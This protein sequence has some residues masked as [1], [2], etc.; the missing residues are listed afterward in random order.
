MDAKKPRQPETAPE[1]KKLSSKPHHG[2]KWPPDDL[3]QV[4]TTINATP[5]IFER[6][7]PASARAAMNPEL[8]V[9]AVDI[10]SGPSGGAPKQFCA[11]TIE[12]VQAIYEATPTSSRCMY[13]VI[14]GPPRPC[15]A[16]FDLETK[17][18]NAVRWQPEVAADE[19]I[20]AATRQ[21]HLQAAAQLYMD[22]SLKVEVITLRCDR[23]NKFSRHVLLKTTVQ[24]KDCSK[25]MP[26]R[27]P[28]DAKTLARLVSTVVS[29]EAASLIDH[30]VYHP[31]RC[32]RLHRS[33][34]LG[35]PEKA[36]FV[37]EP[38]ACTLIEPS[39]GITAVLVPVSET[40]VQPM[41]QAERTM[42]T[43][44]EVDHLMR[45]NDAQCAST[46]ASMTRPRTHC[47]TAVAEK[48]FNWQALLALSGAQ[49]PAMELLPGVHPHI[50]AQ[51]EAPGLPPTPLDGMRQWGEAQ[52]R[53]L[54]C[55]DV[56]AGSP[57]MGW[58]YVR[59]L[60]PE[61]V[62]LELHAKGGTCLTIGRR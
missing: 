38:T 47:N 24:N 51:C 2:G 46:I 53:W 13:E 56:D 59:A 41:V 54:G 17:V 30:G 23:A 37:L 49:R 32:F 45:R 26:L 39:F 34:K 42:R 11:A 1:A 62:Y 10:P 40:L 29:A 43:F 21:L 31:N 18:T 27:S 33:F 5:L 48:A 14:Q 22:E 8:R 52:L 6:L 19:V 20:A 55:K 12:H 9:W 36:P 3:N 58:S 4:A 7:A 61:E 57:V 60:D 44:S 50:A 28:A 16:Y 35:D 25:A 15:W